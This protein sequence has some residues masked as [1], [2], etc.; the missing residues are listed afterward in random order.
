MPVI[1]IGQ[2]C[3]AYYGEVPGSGGAGN[4][5]HGS[6]VRPHLVD[7]CSPIYI[8]R[9]KRD[10]HIS[11]LHFEVYRVR[12]GYM[13]SYVGG[14]WFGKGLPEGLLN[15]DRTCGMQ[16]MAS[17]KNDTNRSTENAMSGKRVTIKKN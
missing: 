1:G 7:N 11:M 9:L 17:I 8:Q 13:R 12:P 5:L 14:N 3:R 4:W 2:D 10:G 16:F 6:V 15:P